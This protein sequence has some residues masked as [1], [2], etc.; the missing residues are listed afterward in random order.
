[1]ADKDIAPELLER[2]R[3]D[4][5]ALLGDAKPAADTY[6]AAADYAELVGSA[7]AE[8]FRRNL[9]ADALPDGRLYWNI[10]DRVVRPLLEEEHL[11]VADASAAVQQALNQQANLG[12]A[13]QR[14]VL[15]TDAVDDLLNKVSTAEQ[16]SDVAWA[17]DEPVRTFSRMVVDDTLKRNVDFQGKAGL[18]PRVIRTAE[19]HCCKW[20]SALAGT[21]DYPR[22]PKDVYRRHERCRCRVEYDPGEGRRQ[23][24]W[25]KT[26]TE[27]EDA[28]QARIQKIQNPSTNRD[29]SAKI[30]ARKQIGLPPVDSP[31]IKAIK[32]AMSEQVLSLPETAQEALRQYTGFTATR[33]NFAIRNGKITPQIQETI[34]ALDNALASGVMPQSVTLYRNTALSFLGFGLP[35]NPTLQDLQDLVDLTPEFPIFISTSFQ[36]LHLPGRDTLIQLHV[37]AGYKGCQFLQPV[38]LPKFK[39][40]D[41]VLFARGMQYRVLDVGRKDDRYFLEI[42][43]LQNV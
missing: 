43:V 2:I 26:W 27:D 19:S 6:A 11:L 1:M 3:A 28:R 14:A 15:P 16:F 20:C 9:T 12:I 13:P 37:P 5:R 34:S 42:E 32:A 25:N 30:E 38:A 41:E 23:N 31:E 40:Q 17:L 22:V 36:D 29:D 4:F 33:V 10:A 39:S 24:V 35:K 8:A 18:W 21:Y 7:L